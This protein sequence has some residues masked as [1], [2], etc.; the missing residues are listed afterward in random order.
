M[1]TLF[2]F[3]KFDR[4]AL[5]PEA[6]KLAPKCK[7]L[8]HEEL[9]FIVLAYDWNSILKRYPKADRIRKAKRM[10]WGKD[11]SDDWFP[12]KD[13]KIMEAI[14]EYNGFQYDENRSLRDAYRS[15]ITELQDMLLA[16][17]PT[18]LKAIDEAIQ[19]LQKRISE[20]EEEI[21]KNDEIA[22]LKGGD[23][24]SFI[25]NWQRNQQKAN[26]EKE[27]MKKQGAKLIE[28]DGSSLQ[29]DN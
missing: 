5:H 25:E 19:R 7:K 12:E 4:T 8:S 22:L 29:T 2:R 1:E 13:P 20:T 18:T 23:R 6:I 27:R 15:K 21:K 17:S 10:V 24:L 11:E 16:A 14:E 26:K 3:N 9:F 28:N